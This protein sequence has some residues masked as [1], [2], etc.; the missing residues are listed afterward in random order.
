MKTQLVKI[1]NRS[2]RVRLNDAVTPWST[3]DLIGDIEKLYGKNAVDAKMEVGGFM[4]SADDALESLDIEINS[5]GGSVLDGYR[6]YHSLLGMRSRGVY[7][8]ATINP[9][10]ASMASVIAMGADKIRM[11]TG[12]R[13]MIHEASQVVAGDSEDHARAAK[14]LDEM[15]GEIAEIYAKRTG[16]KPEEMRKLMKAETW[17]GA[18]EASQRKFVDEVIS[19]VPLDKLNSSSAID[20]HNEPHT[21]KPMSLLARLFPGN[22][23][24]AQVESQFAEIE[25]QAVTIENQISEI[26]NLRKQVSDI[27]L[28]LADANAKLSEFGEIVNNHVATIAAKDAEIA[29]FK[30][31]LAAA[32][33][34][35]AAQAVAIA[36]EAGIEKPLPV[37]GGEKPASE[38]PT[39]TRAEFN[40]LP[41]HARL[42]H[43]KAGG[44]LTN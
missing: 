27:E 24:V 8:T 19:G 17:M 31:K 34:S 7:V 33:A 15:S 41:P 1:E 26:Q 12:G 13:M 44:K 32:E 9:L 40:A 10:A 16:D 42:A 37:D 20:I 14:I 22:D 39:L 3:D 28:S 25:S 18:T 36:A 21:P 5:P 4:A 29:E 2:G 43:V 35:S 38:V 30:D 11:V 6:I 23:Q